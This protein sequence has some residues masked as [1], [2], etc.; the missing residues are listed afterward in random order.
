MYKVLYK[1][2]ERF[3]QDPLEMYFCEQHLP[4][5]WK[6]NL[7]LYDFDYASTFWNQKIFKPI[8]TGNVRDENIMFESDRTGSMSEKIKAEQSLLSPK[9]LSR[10]QNVVIKP[11]QQGIHRIHKWVHK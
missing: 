1:L 8:A 10:H 6:D 5:A 4:G 9:V 3:S 7:P 11:T 2:A